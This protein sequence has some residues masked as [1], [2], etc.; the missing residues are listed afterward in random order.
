MAYV[1]WVHR[2]GP[3]G[4]R[5]RARRDLAIAQTFLNTNDIE[6]DIDGLSAAGTLRRW[7][8]HHALLVR[9]SMVMR[10]DPAKAVTARKSLRV[11][12]GRRRGME[13]SPLASIPQ[14]IT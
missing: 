7:F 10:A 5:A 1:G 3:P 9:A 11:L 4:G 8:E 2:V 14:V 12:L 6:G 13:E